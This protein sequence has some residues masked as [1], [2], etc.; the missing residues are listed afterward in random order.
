MV[1][2]VTAQV[3]VS[4]LKDLWLELQM[5]VLEWCMKPGTETNL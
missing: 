3:L 2:V 5:F 1:I 4:V